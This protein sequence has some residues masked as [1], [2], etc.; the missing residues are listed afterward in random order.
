MEESRFKEWWIRSSSL[1]R[2]DVMAV[3]GVKS[4]CVHT[5]SMISIFWGMGWGI[6]GGRI[7][8]LFH[9]ITAI[10]GLVTSF[11]Q[12]SSCMRTERLAPRTACFCYT[13]PNLCCLCFLFTFIVFLCPESIP[14]SPQGVQ[15]ELCRGHQAGWYLGLLCFCNQADHVQG[16][17]Q[18]RER[19]VYFHV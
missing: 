8:W 4:I 11:C 18:N 14:K 7:T 13:S 12:M 6:A 1:R 15:C 5:L 3:Q 17:V 10:V 16:A 9:S 19:L 2:S